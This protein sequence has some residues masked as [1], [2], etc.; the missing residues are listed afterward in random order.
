MLIPSALILAEESVSEMQSFDALWRLY[1]EKSLGIKA[2]QEQVEAQELS[3]GRG[4]RHWLPRA[5]VAG[6]WY[7]TTDPGQVFFNHLGQRSVTQNDFNPANLNN[8]PSETFKSGVI[9]IDLPLYEGGQKSGQEQMLQKMFESAKLEAKAQK[10]EEYLNLAKNYAQVIVSST[11]SN[12]LQELQK[13]LNSI[14][15]RY[16]VGA[17]NNPVGYSGLLGLKGVL[18]RIEGMLHEYQSQRENAHNW[19]AVKTEVGPDWTPVNQ[20]VRNY[21]AKIFDTQPKGAPSTRLQAQDLKV[22]SL[23]AV[24]LMERSRYLPRVGLFAQNQ[25]YMGERDNENS[26]SVGLY[27]AWELFNS[28]SYGRVAEAN[29]NALSARTKIEAYKQEERIALDYLYDAK[30]AL[31][32]NLELVNKSDELLKEQTLNAL[33]LFSSGMLNALQL[34]EVIN[35]RVDLIEKKTMAEAHYLD[36]T[37]KIYLLNN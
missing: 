26:R 1:Q 21:A 7:N 20:D 31:E 34:A 19:V 10:H 13:S 17:K 24:K 30:A 35:R 32:K 6:Q 9:G 18:N 22:Q 3:L 33:K 27:V 5:Y 12:K 14:V 23:D 37:S 15:D 36:V 4:K 2:A 8:P 11:N 29:A 16:Q 25:H 28:D